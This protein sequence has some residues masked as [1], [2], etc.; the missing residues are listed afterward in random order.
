MIVGRI[1]VAVSTA[2][3]VTFI[4]ERPAPLHAPAVR[5]SS[6]LRH[7]APTLPPARTTETHIFQ[8]TFP[9]RCARRIGQAEDKRVKG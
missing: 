3:V 1:V 2:Q 6:H 8:K 7:S 9:A 5:Q 4:V